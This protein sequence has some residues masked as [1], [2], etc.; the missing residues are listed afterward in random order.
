MVAVI[1][2]AGALVA[3]VLV[4]TIL[5][6]VFAP[7]DTRVYSF[8]RTHPATVGAIVLAL[9]VSLFLGW[10]WW[11]TGAV[12]PCGVYRHVLIQ[13]FSPK[14]TDPERLVEVVDAIVDASPTRECL[15]NTIEA[16]TN[17]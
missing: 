15:S 1:E 13:E 7:A 8:A 2:S 10:L 9:P 11:Q 16:F 4:V 17:E 6:R 5:D 3:I 12:T 14:V